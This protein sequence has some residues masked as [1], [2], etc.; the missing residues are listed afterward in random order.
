MGNTTPTEPT[1]EKNTLNTKYSEDL[2]YEQ[3]YLTWFFISGMV[4]SL[5]D[6]SFVMYAK[7]VHFE[8]QYPQWLPSKIFSKAQ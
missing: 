2:T 8:L 3:L 7:L 1:S 4:S 5:T 6:V